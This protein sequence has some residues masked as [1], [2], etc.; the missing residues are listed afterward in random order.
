MYTQPS[1]STTFVHRSKLLLRF[2]REPKNK[3]LSHNHLLY[4]W[5]NKCFP[6]S[7]IHWCDEFVSKLCHAD[8]GRCSPL[9]PGP[10][11]RQ[12]KRAINRPIDRTVKQ[13]SFRRCEHKPGDT[14]RN[15]VTYYTDWFLSFLALYEKVV[16]PIVSRS[17]AAPSDHRQNGMRSSMCYCDRK[18]PMK[19]PIPT[20]CAGSA[21]RKVLTRHA[22]HSL[23][24]PS[25]PGDT[26][27]GLCCIDNSN[28]HSTKLRRVRQ[29]SN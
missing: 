19:H 23:L 28:S 2:G 9:R 10:G 4:I 21:N 5:Q 18:C 20:L 16:W 13:W 17:F 3:L 1:R 29:S 11:N 24:A 6:R 15:C 27:N 26:A 12:P 25:F 22:H 14:T 8:V 7:S